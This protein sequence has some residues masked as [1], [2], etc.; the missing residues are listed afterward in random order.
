MLNIKKLKKNRML[1]MINRLMKKKNKLVEN[2]IKTI[3]IMVII[4]K[5]RILYYNKTAISICFLVNTRA[6][7]KKNKVMIVFHH[8]NPI[9]NEIFSRLVIYSFY[10]YS[11]MVFI[12][13]WLVFIYL[14]F[15]II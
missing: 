3:G 1:L 15:I 8:C 5:I 11:Y 4:Q 12:L 7:L 6:V 2:K 10:N 14:L 9:D 13:C